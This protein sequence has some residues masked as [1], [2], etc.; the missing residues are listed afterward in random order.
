M[1]NLNDLM[2]FLDDFLGDVGDKDPLLPNGL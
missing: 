1:V 2:T